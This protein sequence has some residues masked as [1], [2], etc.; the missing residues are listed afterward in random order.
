MS[1]A[2][3]AASFNAAITF[4]MAG[5]QSRLVRASRALAPSAVT[6]DDTRAWSGS[7][8]TVP[9]AET[10]IDRRGASS[11]ARAG[12]ATLKSASPIAGCAD[13]GGEGARMF[14]LRLG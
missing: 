12:G 10:V 4:W 11:S 2:S 1:L 13:A 14:R 3:M 8:S 5:E 7:T 6:P 9:E